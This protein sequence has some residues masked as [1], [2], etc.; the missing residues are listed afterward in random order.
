MTVQ[1]VALGHSN[2]KHS[3]EHQMKGCKVNGCGQ[4]FEER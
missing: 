4:Y 1:E 2:E 3:D